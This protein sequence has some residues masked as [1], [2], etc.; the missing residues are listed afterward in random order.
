MQ[1]AVGAIRAGI[2][3]L[4]KQRGLK[5]AD[6]SQL[7]LAGA[8]GNY[9]RKANALRIGLIPPIDC[10]RVRFIGNAAL[11]GAKSCLLMQEARVYANRLAQRT[12]HIDLS[13][14]KEFQDEF[15]QALIFPSP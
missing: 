1:L 6:L 5:H 4:L 7:L 12:L 13:T 8:F 2:N 15:A 11:Q 10:E 9:I 3:L 14:N